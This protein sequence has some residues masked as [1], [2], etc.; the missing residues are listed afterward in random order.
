MPSKKKNV[1]KQLMS[2]TSS[3][4]YQ[5]ALRFNYLEGNKLEKEVKAIKRE[6]QE[7]HSFHTRQW[8]NTYHWSE[9][10]EKNTSGKADFTK[11]FKLMK[12]YDENQDD[13]TVPPYY[14]MY[15]KRIGK[16]PKLMKNFLGGHRPATAT[17]GKSNKNAMSYLDKMESSLINRDGDDD[18]QSEQDNKGGE[19]VYNQV[20]I[21]NQVVTQVPIGYNKCCKNQSEWFISCTTNN[22]KEKNIRVPD[23]YNLKYKYIVPPPVFN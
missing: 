11:H 17:S 3:L 8:E 12:K 16:K 22:L 19:V 9:E 14:F 2:L 6:K 15:G 13:G 4:P 23:Y 21:G 5:S 10:I 1:G 7:A 20:M 18:N